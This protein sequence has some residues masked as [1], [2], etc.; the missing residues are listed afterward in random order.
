MKY[1]GSIAVAVSL[2][3]CA[4]A[5]NTEYE[6][7]DARRTD[8][9]T[10]DSGGGDIDAPSSIDA[11]SIDSANPIDAPSS[12]DAAIPIDAGTPID[13]PISIDAATPIDGG[14]CTTTTVQLLVNGNVD[15]TPRGT[16]WVETP[17]DPLYPPITADTG[18]VAAQS[19]P[20]RIWLGGFTSA[21]DAVEQIVAI[22]AGTT[23][24]VL[25][26]Q[27]A[28]I[29]GE[30]GT[31]VYDSAAIEL[32]S[33]AGA[34]LATPQALTN[35]TVQAAFTPFSFIFATPFAGQSVRLRFRSTNDLSL[36]TSFFWDSLVLEATV[37][38]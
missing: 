14:G 9:A 26:G 20:N 5:N 28:A 11:A 21:S 24:L 29:T 16:G 38:Q 23:Q 12:I 18:G 32:L 4:S 37:C 7:I 15:A 13:A 33:T 27:Y 25:R 22:P 10:I 30:S 35:V 19:A 36:E 31:T 2:A 8:A 1:V 6:G 3:A 34:V 17:V